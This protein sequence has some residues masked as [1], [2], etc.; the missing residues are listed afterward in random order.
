MNEKLVKVT[1]KHILQNETILKFYTGLPN[2][3]IF[4]L[5]CNT[6]SNGIVVDK[7]CKLSTEEELLLVL[8]RLNLGLLEQDIG[9]RFGVTQSTV[10]KIFNKWIVIMAEKLPFLIKWPERDELLKTIESFMLQSRNSKSISINSKKEVS[11]PPY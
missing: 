5:I 11:V 4:K 6:V 8:M 7:K 3:K 2:T 1:F 10:S 9:Y